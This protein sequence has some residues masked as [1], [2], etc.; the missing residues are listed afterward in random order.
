MKPFSVIIYQA[1]CK[2]LQS[3]LVVSGI[4]QYQTGPVVCSEYE[5]KLE[6]WEDSEIILGAAVL[7]YANK[8]V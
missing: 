4:S 2:L 6:L 7:G 5:I 1:A 3:G 8:D